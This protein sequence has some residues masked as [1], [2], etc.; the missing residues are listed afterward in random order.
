MT[1]ATLTQEPA[2]GT[3]SDVETDWSALRFTMVA[4]DDAP[5]Y[6]EAVFR[7]A[8]HEREIDVDASRSRSSRRPRT[9]PRS[10]TGTR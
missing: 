6:D 7:V 1:G 4:D 3:I 10:A 2:H 5:R 9:T 8:G